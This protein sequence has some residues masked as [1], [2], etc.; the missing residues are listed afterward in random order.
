M[1]DS[2]AMT[3][4]N[5]YFVPYTIRS[6]TAATRFTKGRDAVLVEYSDSN[7]FFWKSEI[8]TFAEARRKWVKL[9]RSGWGRSKS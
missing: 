5:G 1:N 2:T 8:M 3:A 9:M 4:V 6:G 7:D